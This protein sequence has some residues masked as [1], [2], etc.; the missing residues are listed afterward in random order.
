MHNYQIFFCLF[1]IK[2]SLFSVRSDVS[3]LPAADSDLNIGVFSAYSVQ[4]FSHITHVEA[5]YGHITALV[6]I[7]L[8]IYDIHT[9]YRL[10]LI[11][12]L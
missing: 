5:D 10:F 6:C 8:K 1:F 9:R 4:Y 12:I 3:V 7:G 11:K 2:L